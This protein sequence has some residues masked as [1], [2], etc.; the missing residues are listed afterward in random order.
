[1]TGYPKYNYPAFFKAEETLKKDWRV[2][3]PA[4][5]AICMWVNHKLIDCFDS[6]ENYIDLTAPKISERDY[7][8]TNFAEL[9]CCDAVCF[10]PGW[11]FSKG[12]KEELFIA[13]CLE[14]EIYTLEEGKIKKM[15]RKEV[16]RWIGRF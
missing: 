7:K 5:L 14:L 11:R 15:Q 4:K 10:L 8:R 2:I 9:S 3:S 6:W 13:K 1:M 16:L 12:A